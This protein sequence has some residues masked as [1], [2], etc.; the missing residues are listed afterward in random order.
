M[1]L[2][3]RSDPATQAELIEEAWDRKCE[4]FPHCAE[5]GESLYPHET[6][7]ELGEKLYCPDCIRS[8]THLTENLEVL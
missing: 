1:H 5:C 4:A 8:A 3:D 6:Y 2:A 7:T